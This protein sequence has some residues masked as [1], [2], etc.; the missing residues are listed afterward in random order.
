MIIELEQRD[1]VC[2]LRIEG[3]FVTGTDPEYLATTKDELKRLKPAKVLVDLT[4]MPYI[5]STGIGFIVG[6]FTTIK[7][8]A[9]RLVMAGLCP[10]VQYVFRLTRL[11]TV[12]PSS[13]DVASGLAYLDSGLSG[14]E[15]S[16]AASQR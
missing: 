3:D 7:V 8:S 10:R 5:G 14:A 13:A 9:G 2:V 6:I 11:D 16:H 1:G 4:E 15:S 12:I